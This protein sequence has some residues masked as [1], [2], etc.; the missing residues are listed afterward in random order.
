MEPGPVD[1][2]ALADE[3]DQLVDEYRLSCLWYLRADYYPRSD[4]E[5]LRV[6]DAIARYG[7]LPAFRR[8]GRLRQWLSRPSS[9]PSVEP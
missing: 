7:D 8:A 6:L 9:A 4:P 2:S 1:R 3:I 5:R